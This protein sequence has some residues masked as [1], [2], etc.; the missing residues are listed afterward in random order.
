MRDPEDSTA[1]DEAM[2]ELLRALEPGSCLAEEVEDYLVATGGPVPVDEAA[3]ERT[4]DRLQARL[5]ATRVR[6]TPRRRPWLMAATL[7]AAGA[8]A[9]LLW[10]GVTTPSAPSPVQEPAPTSP[11]EPEPVPLAASTEALELEPHA[12]AELWG[13]QLVLH[14]GALAFRREG[15][16]RPQATTVRLPQ[17]GWTL[18][19]V[20]TVFSVASEGQ[21]V[22]L[23]VRS[24]QVRVKDE[25][26]VVL[27]ALGPDQWLVAE[28]EEVRRFHD[29]AQPELSPELRALV[30]RAR[31]LTLPERTRAHLE[32]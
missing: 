32:R 19:P 17:R 15:E 25:A 26:G 21:R 7:L 31:W 4:V 16:L 10:Y 27:H 11:I 18:A 24:G 2:E 23:T 3:L 5:N 6:P 9:T 13:E 8:A 22:A 29:Q 1:P 30:R 28:G 20:G 14:A 12:T